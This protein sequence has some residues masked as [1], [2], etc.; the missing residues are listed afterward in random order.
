M[1]ETFWRLVN[2]NPNVIGITGS[3]N[4]KLTMNTDTKSG[5]TAIFIISADGKFLKPIII[6]KGKTK[7]CLKK[8]GILN[9]DFVLMKFSVNGWINIDI[10]KF[11][12]Y[13][14]YKITKG[15]ESA[16]ILDEYSV[17]TNEIIKEEAN[18]LNIKLIYVPPGRTA[19]NQPLDV[20]INGAIKSIGKKIAKEIF[21]IDPFS[22]PTLSES[23]KSLIESK[24]K[25][26]EDIIIKSFTKACNL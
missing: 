17:H 23:I 20:S 9:E 10:M 18:K 6:I 15:S 8:T 24:N 2:D 25:I 13:E 12:L 21:I 1:D 11:I 5:F 3:E 4:R 22:V 16:L 7:R 19:T 14:I 26:S